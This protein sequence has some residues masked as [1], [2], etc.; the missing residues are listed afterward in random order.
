VN[1]L[2]LLFGRLLGGDGM[3]REIL[4]LLSTLSGSNSTIPLAT[5]LVLIVGLVDWNASSRAR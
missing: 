4:S 2:D 1:S 3:P 5:K